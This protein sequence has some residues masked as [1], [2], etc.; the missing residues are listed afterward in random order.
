[1]GVMKKLNQIEQ[2]QVDTREDCQYTVDAFK[3]AV[4]WCKPYGI[5][6]VATDF[7]RDAR[8]GGMVIV[9]VEHKE[10][11]NTIE[12]LSALAKQGKY[13]NISIVQD[14]EDY[15]LDKIDYEVFDVEDWTHVR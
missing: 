13:Y 14:E 11:G 3:F 9:L 8:Y 2:G 4:E 12:C 5:K 6:K 7:K 1:M 15:E 10:D